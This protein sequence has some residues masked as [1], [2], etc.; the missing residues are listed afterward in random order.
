MQSQVV[1][2]TEATRTYYYTYRTGE[3]SGI[4]MYIKTTAHNFTARKMHVVFIEGSFK[5]RSCLWKRNKHFLYIPFIFA[6]GTIPVTGAYTLMQNPCWKS[7]S[8]YITNLNIDILYVMTVIVADDCGNFIASLP[9][10]ML[11]L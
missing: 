10:Y 8:S 6:V 5:H 7:R 3:K 11:T 2:L 1:Y 9:L 4:Y